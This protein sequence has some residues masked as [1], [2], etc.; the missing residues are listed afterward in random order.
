MVHRLSNI[1]R[2]LNVQRRGQHR[3]QGE[4]HPLERTAR[5]Q[6]QFRSHIS[7]PSSRHRRSI[8]YLLTLNSRNLAATLLVDIDLYSGRGRIKR[9]IRQTLIDMQNIA[10]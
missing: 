3:C 5:K 10:F 2:L 1:R 8:R 4:H 7:D 6:S 9:Y